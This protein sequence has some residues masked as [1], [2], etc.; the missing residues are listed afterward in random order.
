VTDVDDDLSP[1]AP[2]ETP[3][4]RK[5][6]ALP[7]AVPRHRVVTIRLTEGEYLC[8][9]YAATREGAPVT[10]WIQELVVQKIR[11]MGE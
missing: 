6:G 5:P 11:E 2:T 3:L 9:Q 7:A 10:R 8:A 4:P 1:P